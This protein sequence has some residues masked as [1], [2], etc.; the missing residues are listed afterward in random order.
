[1]ANDAQRHLIEAITNA[2][3]YLNE[4][5]VKTAEFYAS[6]LAR[7]V[8]SF[9][10]GYMEISDFISIHE[11]LII[12]QM[13][14]AWFE[15]MELNGLTPDDMTAEWAIKLREI[16]MEEQSHVGDFA[17]A[18]ER[19]RREQTG[20][21]ALQAR[22]DLWVVRYTDVVNQA[23]MY[24]AAVG[25]KMEWVYGDTDH[26]ETCLSLNGKVA[27]ALE[28]ARSPYHPQQPPNDYLDCK[29]WRCQCQLVPTS[30]RRTAGIEDI[31]G[32]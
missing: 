11:N 3:I 20:L 21:D 28:W 4:T 10:N 23:K 22:V 30:K 13:R 18:I 12:G 16:I 14:Q 25:Q 32:I 29:G 26:C 9:Y 19:A 6:T 7:A 31:L 17:L 15:G 27:F 8:R 1:M 5:A 24:T 2:I